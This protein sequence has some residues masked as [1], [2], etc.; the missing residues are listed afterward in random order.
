[1]LLGLAAEN[2]V[3]R[4]YT[5][6]N[7]ILNAQREALKGITREKELKNRKEILLCLLLLGHYLIKVA[8]EVDESGRT[9][10]Q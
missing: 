4:F 2:T 1:M 8:K 5:N 7:K 3:S 10:F 6:K 9:I